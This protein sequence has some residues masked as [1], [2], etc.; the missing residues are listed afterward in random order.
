MIIVAGRA[1]VDPARIAGMKAALQAMMQATWE[2]S[3]C[4]SYSLAIENE[5]GVDGPAVLCIFERWDS[6]ASLKAHFTA[7]HMADFNKAAAGAIVS[8]DVKLYDAA[9]ERE[10]KL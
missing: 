6:E 8:L 3:G 10:L 1:E 4:L 2:E 7:P 5:G 9:N